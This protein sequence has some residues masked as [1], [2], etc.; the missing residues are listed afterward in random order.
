MDTVDLTFATV[1]LEEHVAHVTLKATGKGSRMGPDYWRQMPALFGR[2][3]TDEAVR[4]VVISGEGEHFSFGLDLASMSAELAPLLQPDGGARARQQLLA[5]I[6]AMQQ[7]NS[8]VARCRKPVIAAISG[9]CIGGGVD[10]ATACDVRLASKDAKLSVREVKL[11]MVA[12]VGTLARLPG[13]VGEGVARELALTGDDVDAARALRLGLVNEVFESREALLAAARAM[14][15]RMAKHSP[16][17]LGGI[18]EVM[19][20]RSEAVARESLATV[21]L[22]NAAFLPS[23]DLLEAMGAFLERREPT[24]SGE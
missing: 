22:W 18:K 21:A 17:V 20:A 4:A 2:L 11:A 3:D 14:A 6:R 13:I 7:A 5:T 1:S 19:N 15:A 12:D 23:K 9:W 24:F 10:L 16:L 8:A